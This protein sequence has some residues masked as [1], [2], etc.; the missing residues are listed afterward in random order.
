MIPN[1]YLNSDLVAVNSMLLHLSVPF[2]F[3]GYTCKQSVS[4]THCLLSHYVM[5][6]CVVT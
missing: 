5:C 4:H 6:M 1:Y 3:M 2:N